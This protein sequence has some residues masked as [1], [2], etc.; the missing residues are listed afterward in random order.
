MKKKNQS[1][2]VKS[3]KNKK[4]QHKQNKIIS[5]KN[6]QI[7]KKSLTDTN[8]QTSIRLNKYIANSGICSRRE[9]DKLIEAGVVKVNGEIITTLG[10]KVKPTDIVEVEGQRI[11]NEKK[12]Y[13]L[14][15]KPKDYI[16]TTKDPQ[17]RKTVMHL[18]SGACKERVYPVGRLDRQTTGLLLFTNDGELAKKLTHP[19]SRIPK[20][21]H[22]VLNKNFSGTDFEK[23]S[24]G[25][26]LEDGFIKPD[27]LSYVMQSKKELGIQIHSGRN[28]II[29]RIFEHLGYEVVKLDRVMYAG[30]TKKNLPR[31]KWRFLTEKEV[32]FLKML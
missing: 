32:D 3:P 12:V 23:L 16:T 20:L 2:K 8:E 17:N 26:E 1:E 5:K 31:G 7:S 9:A 18:I 11:K 29:R 30:L 21:Y 10:Y 27:A 19:K 28:R 25:I 22:V 4:N 14:L 15:N 6:E 24:K 13:I